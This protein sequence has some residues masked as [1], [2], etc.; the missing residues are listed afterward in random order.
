MSTGSLEPSRV[1]LAM[2]HSKERARSSVRFSFSCRNTLEEAGRAAEI[3][4]A[5]VEKIRALRPSKKG[6]VIVRRAG[7]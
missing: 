4:A 3:I 6:R 7:G 5:A 2:G 1:I